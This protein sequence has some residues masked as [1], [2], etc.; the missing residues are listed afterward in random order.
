MPEIKKDCSNCNHF[1]EPDEFP[2]DRCFDCL[3]S[4]NIDKFWEEDTFVTDK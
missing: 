2:G 3:R 1:G 4:D